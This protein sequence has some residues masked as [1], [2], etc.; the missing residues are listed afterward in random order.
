MA[1]TGAMDSATTSVDFFKQ[2]AY[3]RE[4]AGSPEAGEA[5]DFSMAKTCD[6]RS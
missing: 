6:Q 3:L 5:T 2:L 4:G 1:L